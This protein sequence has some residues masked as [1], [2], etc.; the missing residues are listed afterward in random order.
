MGN[1]EIPRESLEP[2]LGPLVLSAQAAQEKRSM[3]MGL[4][5]LK[6]LQSLQAGWET[7]EV[8]LTDTYPGKALNTL[9]ARIKV[10]HPT[11]VAVVS[12]SGEYLSQKGNWYH[13]VNT[14]NLLL[15]VPASGV[16]DLGLSPSSATFQ[17][18]DPGQGTQPL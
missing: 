15:K 9:Q 2:T 16:T 8:N 5:H 12:L 3:R 4:S 13:L 1:F 6:G 18:C 17:L 10:M 11:V 7:A 14:N